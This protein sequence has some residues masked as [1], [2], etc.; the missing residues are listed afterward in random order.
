MIVGIDVVNEGRLS[1]VGMTATYTNCLMQHF[2]N[3][4]RII[5]LRFKQPSLQAI[6][7]D[8]DKDKSS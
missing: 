3:Q 5:K 4:M 6:D 7:Y 8:E 1:I 2:S